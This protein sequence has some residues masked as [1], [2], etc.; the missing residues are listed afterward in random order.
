MHNLLFIESQLNVCTI[1]SK[2][3]L[4]EEQVRSAEQLTSGKIRNTANFHSSVLTSSS[5]GI[6]G[7]TLVFPVRE[8][9]MS[10]N[11]I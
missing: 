8:T 2:S 10:L 11:C 9:T 7:K 6:F 3:Y 5:T 1:I 4:L